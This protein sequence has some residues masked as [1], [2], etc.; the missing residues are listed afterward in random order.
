MY[1]RKKV[2][3]IGEMRPEYR[4]RRQ[5]VRMDGRTIY[6]SCT[7]LSVCLSVC[8]VHSRGECVFTHKWDLGRRE[9]VEGV[10]CLLLHSLCLL[11]SFADYLGR[12]NCKDT[13]GGGKDDGGDLN[14]LECRRRSSSSDARHQLFSSFASKQSR[15]PE[16]ILQR[17]GKGAKSW[18]LCQQKGK[19]HFSGTN[20]NYRNKA[21]QENA[22]I[23]V[24]QKPFPGS[25]RKTVPN[26]RN[27]IKDFQVKFLCSHY[28]SP[29][30]RL[31]RLGTIIINLQERFRDSERGSPQSPIL[32]QNTALFHVRA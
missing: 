25:H 31:I 17:G 19:Y 26:E 22:V 5:S 8:I 15:A 14:W 11:L 2:D 32:K 16:R 1:S 4:N 13:V 18:C 10:I 28:I 6:L 20:C 30:L 27:S 7:W 29:L 9:K 21:A 23:L 3:Q 24:G 12:C